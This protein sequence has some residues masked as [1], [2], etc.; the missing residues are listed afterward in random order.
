MKQRTLTSPVVQLW[1][2]LLAVFGNLSLYVA[3][4]AAGQDSARPQGMRNISEF[5][6][7]GG[8]YLCPETYGQ[9]TISMSGCRMR[10]YVSEEPI[11]VLNKLAVIQA[12][13][14]I[15]KNEQPFGFSNDRKDRSK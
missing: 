13:V 11:T 4:A 8:A 7:Y 2:I 5:R 9:L 6:P 14:C 10:N 15:D 12:V 1:C 3:P